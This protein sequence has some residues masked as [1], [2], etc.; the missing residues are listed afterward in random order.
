MNKSESYQYDPDSNILI[1]TDRNLNRAEYAYD[2]LNRET[3]VGFGFTGTGY[4]ACSNPV[5]FQS[6]IGYTIRPAAWAVTTCSIV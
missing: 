5:N 1:Y 2:G 4:Q 6:T 3:C